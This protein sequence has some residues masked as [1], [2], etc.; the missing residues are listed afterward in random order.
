MKQQK[1]L[2]WVLLASVFAV[3]AG[4]C[5]STVIPTPSVPV[6]SAPTQ[7]SA[8]P[9]AAH[10][11]AGTVWAWGLNDSGQLG[12][13]QAG[14]VVTNPMNIPDLTEV[15]QLIPDPGNYGTFVLRSDGSVWGWG[16]PVSDALSGGGMNLLGQPQP[17]PG[18]ANIVE[19]FPGGSADTSVWAVDNSGALWTWGVD[20]SSRQVT[21]V[22]DVKSIYGG[23]A[24]LGDGSV[25]RDLCPG[26]TPSQVE[27]PGKVKSMTGDMA[28]TEEGEVWMLT[29]G[30]PKRV[31]ELTGV[32]Q[33]LATTTT[34]FAVMTDGTV[35]AWTSDII[36]NSFI[37]QRVGELT[38]VEQLFAAGKTVF[39]VMADGKVWAWPSFSRL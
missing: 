35:W 6:S 3:T 2:V 22:K 15:T 8:T 18:L 7:T 5:S 1:S 33:V 4:A 19:I 26:C 32:K 28:L 14:Q 21:G 11:Q 12:A 29:P 31:G 38:G 37:P 39:G 27:I 23:L 10:G 25:W 13:S 34:G 36:A 24:L 30:G 20:S 16:D 9:S 17:I